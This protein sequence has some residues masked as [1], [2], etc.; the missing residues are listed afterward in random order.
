MADERFAGWYR[1][2]NGWSAVKSFIDKP[3]SAD[4]L[5]KVTRNQAAPEK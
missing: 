3:S 1:F 5:R 2:A 4:Y